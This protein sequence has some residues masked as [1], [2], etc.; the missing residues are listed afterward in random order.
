M[1]DGQ[2]QLTNRSLPGRNGGTAGAIELVAHRG[3]AA[4]YPENSREGL[5]A[6]VSAGARFLEFDVQL[7]GDGIPVLLHDAS[8]ERTAGR[9]GSVFDHSA[10]ELSRCEVNERT[11]LGDAFRG[12]YIPLLRQVAADLSAWPGV[13]AFVEIKE[14]SLERFGVPFVVAQVVAAL[15]PALDACVLISFSAAAVRAARRQCRRPTG[16]AVRHWSEESR[17]LATLL[18]PQYLFCNH[19][20]FPPWPAPLWPGPWRWVAY[21]VADPG[22]ARR[23]HG[24]GVQLI[25]TMAFAE[26]HQAC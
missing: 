4:R 25:E 9:A 17:Q 21:E 20:K 18:A 1:T 13:T 8:L 26:M 2:R 7:A 12:V 14:E 5:A 16:W 24:R 10:A 22:L 23:L 6:A 15:Q 3:Y 11:R 19:L